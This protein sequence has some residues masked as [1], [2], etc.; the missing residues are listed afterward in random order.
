MFGLKKSI[1]CLQENIDEN[2]G[3]RVNDIMAGFTTHCGVSEI[4]FNSANYSVLDCS[5]AQQKLMHEDKSFRINKIA[6]FKS[7]SSNQNSE[8]NIIPKTIKHDNFKSRRLCREIKSSKYSLKESAKDA[9]QSINKESQRKSLKLSLES[10]VGNPE[11]EIDLKDFSTN[12][13]EKITEREVILLL[14]EEY[15][16]KLIFDCDDEGVKNLI[17]QFDH[18]AE[19]QSKLIN[20]VDSRGNHPLFLCIYLRETY[21]QDNEK[22]SALMRIIQNFL[23]NGLKIRI[24][25]D[26]KR[27]PLE[28]AISYVSF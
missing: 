6:D 22:R 11:Y 12:K 13:T 15:L 14:N 23:S 27:T 18:E 9:D 1:T 26:E 2:S 19:L 10:I 4:N 3:I 21:K 28:E 25:N 8:E 16:Q 17:S 7:M 5:L 24:R 20:S